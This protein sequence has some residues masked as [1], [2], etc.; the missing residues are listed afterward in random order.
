M[1]THEPF[2]DVAARVQQSSAVDPQPQS[3]QRIQHLRCESHPARPAP[4]RS[5]RVLST[6]SSQ[7][8]RAPFGFR[9]GAEP[10]REPPLLP[11]RLRGDTPSPGGAAATAFS[12]FGRSQGGG[13]PSP[14][15]SVA[16]ENE[17]TRWEWLALALGFWP[18]VLVAIVL[19]WLTRC[20]GLR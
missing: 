11:S 7:A 8:D 13:R 5:G 17:F 10:Q 4:S 3:G 1:A 12:R 20:G 9:R 15:D 14:E 16:R 6:G 19:G 18:L 2:P